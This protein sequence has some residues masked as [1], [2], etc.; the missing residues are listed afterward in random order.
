MYDVFYES[1]YERVMTCSMFLREPK[2]E[3]GI[4]TGEI[5]KLLVNFLSFNLNDIENTIIEM[6]LHSQND[7]QNIIFEINRYLEQMTV[8]S[9]EIVRDIKNPVLAIYSATFHNEDDCLNG[10]RYLFRYY[11]LLQKYVKRCVIDTKY[12]DTVMFTTACKLGYFPLPEYKNQYMLSLNTEEEAV[13]YSENI[14]LMK[15]KKIDFDFDELEKKHNERILNKNSC[16][17]DYKYNNST[18]LFSA[19]L[20]EIFLNGYIIKICEN[21]GKFFI[22]YSRSDE[23]Y[24]D[25][26]SPQDETRTCKKYA[27]ERLW[28][29][30]MKS[31]ESKILYRKVYSAK[32]MYVSRHLNNKTCEDNLK[33]FMSEAAIWQRDVDKGIKKEVEYIAWLNEQKLRKV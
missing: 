6:L 24:C 14:V 33:K 9:N 7:M 2:I 16:Y 31:N 12:N 1:K 32:K 29:E 8:L 22:P 3:S 27:N 28:Y 25:N 21:C 15:Q 11:R 20:Y 5:G 26:I 4:Y 18:E 17:R 30:R 13:K 19:M 10:T 23:K